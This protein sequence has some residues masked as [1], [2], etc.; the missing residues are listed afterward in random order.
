[1]QMGFTAAPRLPGP[2]SG[3]VG[4]RQGSETVELLVFLAQPA[5][6]IAWCAL[7]ALAAAWVLHDLAGMR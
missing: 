2:S 7:G 6:V 4:S 3:T 1:M 5:F